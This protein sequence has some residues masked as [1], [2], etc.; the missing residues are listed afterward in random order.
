MC[1]VEAHDLRVAAVL[2]HDPT[3][4][5][6]WGEHRGDGRAAFGGELGE[7]LEQNLGRHPSISISDEWGKLVT[8][9]RK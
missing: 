1:G 5:E 3:P 4:R 9:G 6:E 2:T 7:V 8:C